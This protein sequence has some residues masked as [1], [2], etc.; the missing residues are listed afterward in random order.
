MNQR[1]THSNPR[2]QWV[3]Q[4]PYNPVQLQLQSQ[5]IRQL[6]REQHS[7]TTK[8][9]MNQLVKGF[10]M[11]MHEMVFMTKDIEALQAENTSIQAKLH[12]PRKRLV[13]TSSLTAQEAQALAQSSATVQNVLEVINPSTSANSLSAP[14]RRPPKCSECGNIGHNRL[15]C[16]NLASH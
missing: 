9:A 3:L 4:T 13:H 2:A 5:S 14:P 8:K 16:P 11:V 12:K 6:L 1:S 10:E 7:P 15:K